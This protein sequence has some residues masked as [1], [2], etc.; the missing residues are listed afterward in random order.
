MIILFHHIQKTAGNTLKNAFT[1][2]YGDNS[3]Y[4]IH[5]GHNGENLQADDVAELS[6]G[7]TIM[8]ASHEP[9]RLDDIGLA[10]PGCRYIT[11]LRNPIER[12]LS[13]FAHLCRNKNNS[14]WPQI[15]EAM[16]D[17]QPNLDIF[18]M[19]NKN[20]EVSNLMTKQLCRYTSY[21]A[22]TAYAIASRYQYV[23]HSED[24]VKTITELSDR[25]GIELDAE[26]GNTAYNIGENRPLVEDLPNYTQHLLRET[27]QMD[28]ELHERMCS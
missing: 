5:P 11:L 25:L 16:V 24:M 12:S 2:S 7:R 23:G 22:E 14:L 17:G 15:E 9:N 28:L 10:I 27:N 13:H 8:V 6:I 26:I 20:T 19:N 21:N 4:V 1:A 18:L 3:L